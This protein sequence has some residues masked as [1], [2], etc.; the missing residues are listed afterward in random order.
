MTGHIFENSNE[1]I[2]GIFV[3]KTANMPTCEIYHDEGCRGLHR[4]GL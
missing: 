1:A 3:C 2:Q 4:F